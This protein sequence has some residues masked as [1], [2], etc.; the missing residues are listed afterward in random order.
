MLLLMAS[1][2]GKLSF[3]QKLK[4]SE[5]F[6]IRQEKVSFVENWVLPSCFVDMLQGIY[7][8]EQ[9]FTVVLYMYILISE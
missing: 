8:S 1:L 4:R 5:E 3:R 9:K 2:Q 7:L 6:S